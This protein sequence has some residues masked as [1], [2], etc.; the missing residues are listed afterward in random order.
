MVMLSYID[1][2]HDCY[3]HTGAHELVSQSVN[4]YHQVTVATIVIMMIIITPLKTN[5]LIEVD[6]KVYI[7]FRVQKPNRT[8][9]TRLSLVGDTMVQS[10]TISTGDMRNINPLAG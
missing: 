10:T 7:K 5:M 3:H 2:V 4:R 8:R 1:F 6:K 9:A